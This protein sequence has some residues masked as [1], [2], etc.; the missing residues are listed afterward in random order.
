MADLGIPGIRVAGG[1]AGYAENQQVTDRYAKWKAKLGRD[2]LTCIQQKNAATV[3]A[4]LEQQADPGVMDLASGS[5][6]LHFATKMGDL[7]VMNEVLYACIR[8][9][10]DLA[11]E[12]VK[13]RTPL[14][15]ALEVGQRSHL[16]ADVIVP[17]LAAGKE[18][19]EVVF[20]LQR[21]L[22]KWRQALSTVLECCT[23]P[24]S[25][26]QEDALQVLIESWCFTGDRGG[27]PSKVQELRRAL[28]TCVAKNNVGGVEALA[29]AKA[30]LNRLD[31]RS[32]RTAMELSE[33][34]LHHPVSDVL[35][36]HGAASRRNPNFAQWALCLA[37]ARGDIHSTLK[38]IEHG[39]VD[40]RDTPP[41][42][43]ATALMYAAAA[44]HADIAVALLKAQACPALVDQKGRSPA[45]L[46]R[47][48]GHLQ[49]AQQLELYAERSDKPGR[50]EPESWQKP[51]DWK[52]AIPEVDEDA[53]SGNIRAAVRSAQVLQAQV[54]KGKKKLLVEVLRATN[55]VTSIFSFSVD[56]VVKVRIG[57]ELQ[58]TQPASGANP[59]WNEQFHF[60][61]QGTEVIIFSVWDLDTSGAEDH[62]FIARAELP[63]KFHVKSLYRGHKVELELELG[64]QIDDNSASLFVS[65]QLADSLKTMRQQPEVATVTGSLPSPPKA[66]APANS[67]A[68]F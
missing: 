56:P 37:A 34:L 17:L 14:D 46:A 68:F 19:K 66:A 30:D 18:A 62:D 63:L 3:K 67:A 21:S 53:K 65:L 60:F 8:S 16:P 2:L 10:V 29:L 39:E 12:D 47:E 11:A 57:Q 6:A 48:V 5:S 42:D 23:L 27:P 38:W 61:V 49:L 58:E 50:L 32:S 59:E 36:H 28:F 55:L 1:R 26:V 33:A 13:Q 20:E 43:R 4:C 41:S 44:G 54:P 35:R 15:E 9:K 51:S 52:E 7:Q 24:V 40:W 45:D 31:P 25:L 64:N 22:P